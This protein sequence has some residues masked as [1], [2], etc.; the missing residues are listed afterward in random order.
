MAD[1]PARRDLTL[2]FDDVE[3]VQTACETFRTLF[4]DLRTA[5]GRIIV[6]QDEVVEQTLMALFADGH[7]LLEGVPGLGKTLLVR[8][9]GDALSMP[10][11]R[12]QFTPDVMPADITGTNMVLEDPTTGTRVFTFKPGPIFHQLILAD[13][14]NRATPK[15]QAALLEAMQERSVTVAGR[16]HDLE[17]PF[18]VMATQNPIEQE[19]TYPLPEAQLDRFL[20]KISVPFTTREELNEI[21]TETTTHREASIDAVLD[22][23]TILDAQ[24]LVRRIVVA[25]H[26][27]DFAI[28]LVMATHRGGEHS[29]RD[30]ER[31]ISIGVS[32]RGGQALITAAKVRA[33]VQGRYAVSFGD[34]A[35]IAGP[36]LRHRILPSFEAEADGVTTDMIVEMLLERVPRDMPSDGDA[37]PT[38]RYGT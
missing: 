20:F 34:I 21:L 6:G 14:I 16:T 7:V 25:P 30:A 3:S 26:V 24:A 23:A 4:Q 2:A 35:A 33:L 8:T 13:E 9:L 27:Q 32:P 5:I 15:S 37:A 38:V 17:R 31:Y 11:A 19:G 10:Y 1:T 22:V 18:L 29:I 12:I 28:R 36:A